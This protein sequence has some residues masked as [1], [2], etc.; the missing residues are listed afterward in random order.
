MKV[1]KKMD[2]EKNNSLEVIEHELDWKKVIDMA[3]NKKGWGTKYV[4]YRY[5]SATITCQME[6]FDFP[7]NKATFKITANYIYKS[8]SYGESDYHNNTSTEYF[9]DNFTIEDFKSLVERRIKTLMQEIIAFQTRQD[10][11]NSCSNLRYYG[12]TM[13]LKK[14]VE[15]TDLKKDYERVLLIENNELKRDCLYEIKER[16]LKKLNKKYYACKDRYKRSNSAKIKGIMQILAKL[17]KKV[18]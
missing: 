5:G 7:K 13:N 10:A 1:N 17:S 11:E 15:K 14:E 9:M 12:W 18:D 16:I 2:S 4:L 3:L 8:E 6:S